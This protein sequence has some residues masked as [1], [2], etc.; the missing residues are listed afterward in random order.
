[1]TKKTRTGLVSIS[2]PFFSYFSTFYLYFKYIHPFTSGWWLVCEFPP[3][4][5]PSRSRLCGEIKFWESKQSESHSRNFCFFFVVVVVSFF[6]KIN[7]IR[8]HRAVNRELRWEGRLWEKW[9]SLSVIFGKGQIW[10]R[11]AMKGVVKRNWKFKLTFLV[12]WY[13]GV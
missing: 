8:C 5:P 1:M 7:H 4:T 2:V 6:W 11:F 9:V 13:F 3:T 10:Q 12:L